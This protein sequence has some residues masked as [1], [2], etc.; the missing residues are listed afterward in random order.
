[1][2][3]GLLLCL[4]AAAVS[5]A[6]LW[7]SPLLVPAL[8]AAGA[9]AALAGREADPVYVL[10]AGEGLVA[11]VGLP[12]LPGAVVVQVIVFGA[13]ADTAGLLSDRRDAWWL[14]LSAAGTAF[15]GLLVISFPGPLPPVALGAALLGA[16]AFALIIGEHRLS[17]GAGP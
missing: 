16:A 6:A 3:T 9:L 13:C 14:A 5:A 2:R 4:G 17:R 11:T 1:M 10:C 7:G 8:V 12:S 15:M